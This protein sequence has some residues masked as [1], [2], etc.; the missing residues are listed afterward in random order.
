MELRI[1][2]PAPGS[3]DR[4]A[5]LHRQI[6]AAIIDG[7]LAGDVRLPTTRE[8]AA[9]LGVSRNT[10]VAAYE[11]LMSEG[12]LV[13]RQR[14]GTFVATLTPPHRAASGSSRSPLL[15][16]LPDAWRHV[17][18]WAGEAMPAGPRFDFRVGL[19]D[20]SQLPWDVWRRLS[21]RAQRDFARTPRAYT[22]PAGEPA[23]REA[24]AG[25]V[26]A[27]RAVA[28]RADDVLI[29][30]GAQHA[31]SLLADLLVVP[32]KTVVA[33][34]DPGYAPL[35]A[36]MAFRGAQLYRAALDDEGVR[37]D[38]LPSSAKV[39]CVTPSHQFPVGTA[40]S[41][42]RR[43][44]LL[45]FARQHR[46]VIIE[47]DYDGE[48]RFGGHPLDALHSLD[49]RGAVF[50]VGTFSKV[51]FPALRVGFVVAPAWAR[52]RLTA[53]LHATH[54]APSLLT[55]LTL[56]AF[57][58]EGHLRRHVRRMHRVYEA[59]RDTLLQAIE[60]HAR[61]LLMPLPSAAGLH[62]SALLSSRF[63]AHAIAHLAAAAGVAVEPLDRAGRR[64]ARYNGLTFGLGLI[65]TE[66]VAAGV[67]TLARLTTSA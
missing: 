56:A 51:L 6:R 3:R 17:R 11:N 37:V 28:C 18:P 62:V 61:G 59:R 36:A 20:H 54:G 8:L 64:R 46:A 15:G 38:R 66:Q 4:I 49:D 58:R 29:T 55:Q 14:A 27:S 63:D 12:Y 26:S 16:V 31:F 50:Y 32:Q 19:P 5:A 39:V 35:H 53:T 47:D 10:V 23:L 45:D 7:R 30:S 44:Q 42:N 65:G 21:V 34:E 33:V 24:I 13:S 60:R 9:S 1:D 25:H 67:A 2:V 40:M 41:L 57:I 48:F 52:E 43:L 22:N